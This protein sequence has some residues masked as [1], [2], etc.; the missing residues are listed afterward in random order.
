MARGY[1]DYY[2]VSKSPGRP[3]HL[4]ISTAKSIGIGAP[5]ETPFVLA[6]GAIQKL[7]IKFPFG[8]VGLLYCNIF[9]GANQIFPQGSG[10]FHGDGDVFKY[11]TLNYAMQTAPYTLTVKTW[12]DDDTFAHALDIY[13]M[14]SQVP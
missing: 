5:D 2:T 12:N 1:P 9:D 8:S 13:L 10:Y 11:D 6:A 14:L 3:Y 7:E 4:H